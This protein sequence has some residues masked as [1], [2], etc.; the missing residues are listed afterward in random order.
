M[1][2]LPLLPPALNRFLRSAQLT[3]SPDGTLSG[4]VQGFRQ[5]YPAA[6]RR[7]ELLRMPEAMRKRFFE[8]VLASSAQRFD[9]G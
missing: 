6:L 4:A 5:G 9:P 1:V 2:Q 7:A 3:L 8:N